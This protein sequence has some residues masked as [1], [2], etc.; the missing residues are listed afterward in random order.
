MLKN[1]QIE[2][3]DS[4]RLLAELDEKIY[5]ITIETFPEVPIQ[6]QDKAI[7]NSTLNRVFTKEEIEQALKHEVLEELAL[8]KGKKIVEK[9]EKTLT[10]KKIIFVTR[11]IVLSKATDAEDAAVPRLGR[12]EFANLAN[13]LPNR[14]PEGDSVDYEPDMLSVDL[15]ISKIPAVT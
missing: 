7:I 14:R 15:E 9:H 6:S 5:A 3:R 12:G 10:G 11:G 4:K 1:G 13:L 2:D 8:E